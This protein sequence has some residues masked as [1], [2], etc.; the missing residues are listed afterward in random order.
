MN[1]FDIKAANW[2][3]NLMHLDRAE[4]IANRIREE[5]PLNKSMTAL[6]FGAGTGLTSFLLSK[7][8]NEI[9]MMDNSQEMVRVMN[10]KI[11]K[12]GA[13]NLKAV[14]FDLEHSDYIAAKFD[15]IFTQ[16]VTHHIV[17]IQSLFYKFA[18]LLNPGGYLAIADLYTENG[19][20]H[21]ENFKGHNGFDP[22][23]L[24]VILRS[25]GFSGISHK[26]CYTLEREVTPG[27]IAKFDIFLLTGVL[28]KQ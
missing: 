2:D 22:E 4:K 25:R 14:Y 15:L 7:Y 27:E 23:E 3:A 6:E 10:E 12:S 16:M 20:F 17:D 26:K 18:A 5:I 8:L 28:A 21:G 1:E 19:S 13:D 11:L 24:A 9:T